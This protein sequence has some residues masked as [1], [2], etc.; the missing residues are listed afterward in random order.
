MKKYKPKFKD[1]VRRAI[2]G[3]FKEEIMREARKNTHI[4]ISPQQP[5][6]L[7]ENRIDFKE[8]CADITV[9]NH[10]E[11]CSTL[12]GGDSS[13]EKAVREYRQ[14]LFEEFTKY[15]QIDS[16]QLLDPNH[17]GLRSIRLSLFIGK[18]K[19]Y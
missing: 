13:Y 16:K 9:E 15:V 4:G 3:F 6:Y 18:L 5:R 2:F 19:K 8:I 1:R 12:E 14:Q 11:R 7:P 17:F 10:R